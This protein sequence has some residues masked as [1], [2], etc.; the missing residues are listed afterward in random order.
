MAFPTLFEF[1]TGSGKPQFPASF[2]P[3]CHIFCA[4]QA[5]DSNDGLAKFLDDRKT[6]VSVGDYILSIAPRLDGRGY[7][8]QAGRIGVLGGSVDFAGAPFYAGMS[9]LRVG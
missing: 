9:A 3:T 1:V 8:G 5:L 4:T 6:P 2:L 7:K